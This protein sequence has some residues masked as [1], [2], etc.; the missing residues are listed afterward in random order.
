MNIILFIISVVSINSRPPSSPEHGGRTG[1]AAYERVELNF[2][3]K[4]AS[5]F[6][7]LFPFK[8]VINVPQQTSS[9]VNARLIMMPASTQPGTFI[10]TEGL[11]AIT[12]SS[13]AISKSHK[14]P[15]ISVKAP[16][17][18]GGG[19]DAYIAQIEVFH[20]IH[21]LNELR[22]EIYYD[23]YYKSGPPDE[24]HRSH[25]AHCI[26][27][28]LQAVTCAAD[29]G[30]ISH[31]WVH[32]EN[33]EEPKTRPMPDFNVVKMCRDFDSLLDWSRENGVKGLARK[34]RDLKYPGGVKIVPGDGYA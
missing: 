5:S 2:D 20:Q 32:N 22:K 23:H 28:L 18:W 4:K 31:N 16:P 3:L 7:E 30:L 8:D 15:S 11:E 12:V 10:S 34:W 14:D 33:I 26:H 1:T 6:C 19:E 9:S 25:K 29:V 24:L 17:S 27:M 13:A 21:C